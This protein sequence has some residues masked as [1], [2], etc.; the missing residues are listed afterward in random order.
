MLTRWE[1][2]QQFCQDTCD[3]NLIDDRYNLYFKENVQVGDG[4]TV[5]YWSDMEAYTVIKKTAKTLTLRRC[6]A[7]LDPNFKPDFVPGGFFGRVMNNSEQTYTYEED[8]QGRVIRAFWS[9]VE[10]RYKW[11]GLY[12]SPGRH[13]FYDYNF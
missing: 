1:F 13:E 6:K 4:A 3:G 7:T 11:Q 8:E 2:R 10:K 5:S 12:V 9:D